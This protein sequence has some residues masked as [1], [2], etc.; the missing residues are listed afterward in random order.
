MH[1]YAFTCKKNIALKMIVV[2]YYT[3]FSRKYAYKLICK[4][5]PKDWQK[6][7]NM[8]LYGRMSGKSAFFWI[9]GIFFICLIFYFILP[10]LV[11]I[12][13]VF[14][15]IAI[16]HSQAYLGGYKGYVTHLPRG[17]SIRQESLKPPPPP[18]REKKG[19]RRKKKKTGKWIRK[20][21]KYY[22][23]VIELFIK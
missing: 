8:R 7:E 20:S 18:T 23:V 11:I 22:P 10:T 21:S 3:I 2:Y 1:L 4:Y 17:E 13:L 9:P 15:T 14:I 6:I 19:G 16:P 12:S 5:F